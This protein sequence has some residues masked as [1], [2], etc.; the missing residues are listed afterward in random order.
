MS[1]T[2]RTL[3]LLRRQ[4]YLAV[5][6]ERWLPEVRRKADLLRVA[7]VLAIH[8]R[9]RVFLLVQSTSLPHVGDRM[10]RCLARPELGVWLQAGGLFEVHGWEQWAGRWQV[11]RVGVSAAD[12]CPVVLTPPRPRRVA[13]KGQRQGVLFNE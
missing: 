4:G 7:D 9:E 6:V 10:A 12:L 1:P 3:Q 13:R 11:K 2:A 8:P 5:P